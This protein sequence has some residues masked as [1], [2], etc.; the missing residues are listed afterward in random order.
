[1]RRTLEPPHQTT[2]EHG[3]AHFSCLR[4]VAYEIS[5]WSFNR[6]NLPKNAFIHKDRSNSEVLKIRNAQLYNTGK[7]ECHGTVVKFLQ[8]MLLKQT[9][10]FEAT[11]ILVVKSKLHINLI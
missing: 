6:G 3:K 2:Y 9:S 5:K 1:M 7:Y 10:L 11:G 8:K 4:M